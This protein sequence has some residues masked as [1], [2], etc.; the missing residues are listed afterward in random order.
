MTK[1][2]AETGK[3]DLSFSVIEVKNTSLLHG[4]TNFK[5]FLLKVEYEGELQISKSNLFHSA[6][7]DG[8][9]NSRKSC[10]LL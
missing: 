2:N 3:K 1:T 9:N 4:L 5:M 7:A 10:S 6:N 8:K